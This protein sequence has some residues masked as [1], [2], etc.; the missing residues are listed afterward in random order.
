M[1]MDNRKKIRRDGDFVKILSNT[2][3]MVFDRVFILALNLF[4]S[5]KIAN[6]YGAMGYG[7]YQYA[8]NIIA[9]F[10]IV[11]TFVDGR[12][13]KQRYMNYEPELVMLTATAVRVFLSG[14]SVILGLLFLLTYGG[15]FSFSVMFFLLL[16]NMAAGSIKFGMANRFEYLLKS[17]KIV[18]ASDIAVVA[19]SLLQLLAVHG[20][21]P[22]H[23]LA[24][25]ALISTLISIGIVF[26]QYRAEFGGHKGLRPDQNLAKEMI[27][28][29]V[30]LALAGSCS[31]LYARCD[32]IMLGAM[33]TSAEVGIYSVSVSLINVV[34]I[35]IAP[36][37]E[38]VYPK[39]IHL[40]EENRPEYVRRYIQI[41]SILTWI[42]IAG[43]SFSFVILP[44]LFR[45]LNA[46]YAQAFS[47]Y[48]I[49]VL[50][51]FFMYN[52]A[53]REGHFT[54]NHH[55]SVLTYSQF[56]SVCANVVM[57]LVG[58]RLWGIYGAAIATVITQAAS[59]M[60]SNLFFKED[61]WEVLRWQLKAWNPVH[62][63]K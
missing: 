60:L 53:L 2:A 36:I 31:V 23:V 28:E 22:V 49:H 16:L 30:P 63:W 3:W 52:A 13:V 61:G 56:V 7:S 51:T 17:K 33:L 35:A 48:Q 4:V 12:V 45:F 29:S 9:V 43:V 57:N 26:L 44:Y 21:R 15:S 20:H 58:I 27:K 47:V 34:Q 59:L 5:V 1:K 42:Y 62:I 39:L 11:A 14:I 37:R 40:Y 54:L 50:G 10:E 19:A 8:V 18:I 46:E 6:Y 38:S 24:L 41:S 25:I 32:S 55:G